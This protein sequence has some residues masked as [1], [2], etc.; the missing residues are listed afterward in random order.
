MEPS[1]LLNITKKFESQLR[2]NQNTE[3]VNAFTERPA[4]EQLVDPEERKGGQ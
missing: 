3:L 1:H 4:G 2:K